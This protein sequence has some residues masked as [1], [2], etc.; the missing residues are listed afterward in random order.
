MQISFTDTLI[1]H[2]RGPQDQCIMV[3]GSLSR[4][5]SAQQT[6]INL[7]RLHLQVITLS[8]MYHPES[9][10]I[11]PFHLRGER[12]PDQHIRVKT[13]PRQVTP[14]SSLQTLWRTYVSTQFLRY[15]GKWRN[16]LG[17]II[18]HNAPSS[19]QSILPPP[20]TKDIT[21]AEYNTSLPKWYQ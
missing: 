20:I 11:C 5:S 3:P 21:L 10:E 7:V 4:D 16:P 1:V 2:M 9:K 12:R 17:P 18:M 13:W 15:S 19:Q 8:D 6:D 14:T